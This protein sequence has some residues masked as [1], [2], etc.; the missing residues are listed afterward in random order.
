MGRLSRVRII[1]VSMSAA[2]GEPDLLHRTD[3]SEFIPGPGGHA[4][5]SRHQTAPTRTSGL[6]ARRSS[7]AR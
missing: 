7:V 4:V 2:R 3:A 6:I 1:C 5:R